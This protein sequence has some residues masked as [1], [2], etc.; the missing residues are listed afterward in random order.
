[1]VDALTGDSGEWRGYDGLLTGM[2]F[3][4]EALLNY[5]LN[6][7]TR[8]INAGKGLFLTGSGLVLAGL[9][10]RV[11]PIAINSVTRLTGRATTEPQMLA[12]MYPTI[13]TWWVPE[14]GLGYTFAAV[15]ICVG[16][17][18]VF[19]GSKFDRALR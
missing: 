13:P 5:F 6:P 18:V 16:L 11:G 10:F 7:P 12:D 2:S 8:L 14:T 19:V 1:M 15:L 9:I 4:Y 3:M 17:G